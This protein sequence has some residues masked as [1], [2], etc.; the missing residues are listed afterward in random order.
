[1]HTETLPINREDYY[2]TSEAMEIIG[3]KYDAMLRATGTGVF[4]KT[5]IKGNSNTLFIPKDEV[6]VLRGLGEVSSKDARARVMA[7]RKANRNYITEEFTYGDAIEN[8]PVE[9]IVKALYPKDPSGFM[10][11]LGD[12]LGA[13]ILV[14]YTR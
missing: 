4:T 3:V 10:S 2:S 7:V 14:E 6:E 8:T 12:Y 9:Q 5:R 11:A 13:R 1:M